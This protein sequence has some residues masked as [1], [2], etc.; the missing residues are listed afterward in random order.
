[1]NTGLFGTDD[2]PWIE[3]LLDLVER[4]H[5]EP[6]RVLLERVEHSAVRA[7]PGRVNR[8]LGALRRV[9]GGKAN[10]AK[11]ARQVRALVLGHP[12]LNPSARAARFVAAADELGL[13]PAEIEPLLWADLATERPV[14][15]PKGRPEGQTL[16]AFANLERIQAAVRKAFAV[17]VQVFTDAHELVR[18]AARLGL[19]STVTRD[20]TGGITLALTGPLA[21]FHATTVYGRALAALV[22]LLARHERYVL[23]IQTAQHGDERTLRFAPPI[24]LPVTV[25]GARTISV[26]ERLARDLEA[27]G[28]EVDRDPAPIQSGD[29]ILFADLAVRGWRIEI[30]GFSTDAYLAH[31]RERYRAAGV[32][33]VL[34]CVDRERTE[35]LED[36]DA[37]VPYR[38]RVDADR[39][40]ARIA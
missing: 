28:C 40:L 2:L 27:L 29:T 14:V 39:V 36:G 24:W 33:N 10:R 22:P 19:L 9:M 23:E 1:M 31:K 38:R 25:P 12:A 13:E 32:A 15:L 20:A 3:P 16:A 5:G 21:L 7:S 4:S 8:V 30:V 35:L 18:A 11:V 17:R 34:L 37:V 26:A 6:W